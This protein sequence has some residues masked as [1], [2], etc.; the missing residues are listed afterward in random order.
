MNGALIRECLPGD[1]ARVEELDRAWEA[2]DSTYGYYAE[3]AEGFAR[4]L[5]PYF[6]VA[7]IQG[8]VVGFAYG[9]VHT[10]EGMAVIP[11]G[12]T[13]FE[14][15]AIYVTAEHRNS[16]IGGMLL[17]KLIEAVRSD[18]VERFSVYTTTKDLERTLRFYRHHAFKP[19][20]VRMFR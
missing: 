9:S 5:G 15:D 7:D 6:L 16:G 3:G 4:R 10:S 2:E 11:V 17:D 13:Y 19:W 12:Q 1:I 20:Y 14:V 8:T 18:G